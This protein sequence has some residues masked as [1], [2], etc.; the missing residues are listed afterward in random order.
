MMHHHFTKENITEAQLYL[1]RLPF[2]RER[3]MVATKLDE[4]LI[5]LYR[6]TTDTEDEDEERIE[7]ENSNVEIGDDPFGIEPDENKPKYSSLRG[8]RARREDLMREHARRGLQQELE[9]AQL[10]T[11]AR[12][13][14]THEE[15]RALFSL[16][17]RIKNNME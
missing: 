16:L 12:L 6:M 2:S 1:S 11:G 13:E 15:L 9:A 7:G 10:K 5:W 4:A 8:Q 14:I 17:N 3:E